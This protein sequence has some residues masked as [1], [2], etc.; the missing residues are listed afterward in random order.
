MILEIA[1]SVTVR[2]FSD[3]PLSEFLDA[4]RAQGEGYY[5]VGLDS[6]TGFLKVEKGGR[7]TFIHSGPG[8]GVVFEEP[9]GAIELSASRYRV[10][11][12]ITWPSEVEYGSAT[13]PSPPH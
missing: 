3:R 11:G 2:R 10:T 6:H 12:K 9:E 7:V 5:V 8:R 4:I 13:A 1:D